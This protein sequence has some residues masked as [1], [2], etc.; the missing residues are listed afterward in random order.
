MAVFLWI[1]SG[2]GALLGLAHG[3]QV[4]RGIAERA[5]ADGRA[6]GRLRAAYYALWTFA[7]W[8]LFG[9]YVLAFWILGLIAYPVVHA[10]MGSRAPD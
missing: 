6:S 1:G 9:F 8:T 4:Y 5:P 7:L 10:L 2:L 3:I